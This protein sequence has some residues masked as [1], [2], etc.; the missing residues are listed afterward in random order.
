MYYPWVFYIG[1]L[2][3][4]LL[5]NE[6]SLSDIG[7]RTIPISLLLLC[8]IIKKMPMIKKREHNSWK[9]IK[10]PLISKLERKELSKKKLKEN[11]I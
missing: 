10:P 7:Y 5:K 1:C 3:R 6:H 11:D 2:I 9:G 4:D 8:E